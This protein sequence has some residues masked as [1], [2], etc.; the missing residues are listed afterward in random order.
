MRQLN[1]STV[2][3]K[4]AAEDAGIPVE[5]ND[6]DGTPYEYQDSEGTKKVTITV[7]GSY[8]NIHRAALRAQRDRVMA[9]RRAKRLNGQALDAELIELSASCCLS[10]VGLDGFLGDGKPFPC[11][12]E[13]AVFLLTKA[14]WVLEQ[15]QAAILDHERFF[16]SNSMS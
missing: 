12:K 14:P 10:W 13:N 4:T 3:S 7:A 5:I 15:V 8:S 16:G 1:L 9:E 11:T 6:L 2:E